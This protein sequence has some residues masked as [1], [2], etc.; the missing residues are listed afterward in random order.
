M[1]K[2]ERTSK[3]LRDA[4]FDEWERLLNGQSSHQQARAFAKLAAPI[5]NS[6]KL[7]LYHA[8][9]LNNSNGEEDVKCLP[10]IRL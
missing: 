5:L 1:K 2:I 3:G 8:R 7:E 6:V 9:F 10:P 4:L